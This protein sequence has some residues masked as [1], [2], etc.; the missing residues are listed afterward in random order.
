MR[1]TEFP[2]AADT[3]AGGYITRQCSYLPFCLPSLSKAVAFGAQFLPSL[4]SGRIRDA[5]YKAANISCIFI[6]LLQLLYFF[7]FCSLRSVL[8]YRK[9]R[10]LLWEVVE[11]W[12]LPDSGLTFE[13][14]YIKA[15]LFLTETSLRLPTAECLQFSSLATGSIQ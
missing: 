8:F 4:P 2:Q 10:F 1:N 9:I 13:P 14:F 7:Y 15:S 5:G 3:L 11:M 6:S 12:A